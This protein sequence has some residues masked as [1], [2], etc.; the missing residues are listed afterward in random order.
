M[1]NKIKL[2]VIG[3]LC[4]FVLS[5]GNNGKSGKVVY[6]SEDKKIKIYESE[7]NYEVE[8]NLSAAGVTEKEV[9]QAQLE[10]MKLGII[11]NLALT[12]A[13]ALEGKNQNLDKNKKYTNG[14]EN[15]KESLLASVTLAE[16]TIVNDISDAKLKEVY[17]ANKA[18]FERKEDAVRLQLMIFNVADKAKAEAALKEAVASPDKFS[19]LVKK[20]MPTAE[21]NTGETAEIP[22][23][24]LSKNYGAIN[25]AIKDVQ[26]G[27][28]VNQVITVNNE[29]YVVKVLEKAPK[30]YIEFEKV[31][32]QI[33]NQLVAQE[34]QLKSQSF[35]QEITGKYKLD[36]ITKDKIKL[37]K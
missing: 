16:R 29:V 10:Q 25:D 21:G 27:K 19:E 23:S 30:G 26:A 36:Q 32:G 24:E 20:Y 13:I 12:R 35:I 1:K 37:S 5:C 33:K 6:E 8:K 9:P 31:K 14:V 17:E 22:L 18:S 11:Q 15:A 3:I 28:V 4:V 7:L 34:K 2:A